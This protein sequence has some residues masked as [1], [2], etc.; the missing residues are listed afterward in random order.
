MTVT[1]GAWTPAAT[2]AGGAT[3][4]VRACRPPNRHHRF[5]SR[6]GRAARRQAFL[7]RHARSNGSRHALGAISWWIAFGPHVPGG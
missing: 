2:S 4:R 1:T 5:P 3:Y 7:V 6:P